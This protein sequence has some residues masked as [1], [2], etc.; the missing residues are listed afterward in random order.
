MNK[1]NPNLVRQL[2][3]LFIILFL[4]ILIFKELVPYIS[5]V[6]GAITLFVISR[7]WMQKLV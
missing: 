6:L 1:L 2:L 4:G 3:V 7:N 5:G